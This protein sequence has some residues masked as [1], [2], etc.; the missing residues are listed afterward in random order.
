MLLLL[1]AKDDLKCLF[2]D[3]LYKLRTTTSKRFFKKKRKKNKHLK[4]Y[5]ITIM[6]GRGHGDF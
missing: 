1:I 3:N 6:G 5:E 4:D 2:E